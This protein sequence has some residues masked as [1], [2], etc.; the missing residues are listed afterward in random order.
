MDA[1]ITKVINQRVCW[2]RLHGFLSV[3]SSVLFFIANE[4]NA[5][6]IEHH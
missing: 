1:N 4:Y 3:V 2:Q 5:Y 6:N